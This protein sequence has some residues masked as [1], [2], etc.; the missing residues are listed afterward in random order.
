MFE[1]V[2][3]IYCD[4]DATVNL[5]PQLCS[6]RTQTQQSLSFRCSAHEQMVGD[7][8]REMGFTHVSL[9]SQTMPMVR[10]VPRGFTGG[11]SSW[12]LSELNLCTQKIVRKERPTALS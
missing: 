2:A 9:S 3:A 6:W 4:T 1:K 5:L 12:S 10:V 11:S 7:I 8:A